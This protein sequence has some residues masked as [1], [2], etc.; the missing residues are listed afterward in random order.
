MYPFDDLSLARQQDLEA[1]FSNLSSIDG[2]D[3]KE[4]L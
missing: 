1:L 4:H 2:G 3:E